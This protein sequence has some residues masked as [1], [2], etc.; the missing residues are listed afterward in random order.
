[1]T[2]ED[3]NQEQGSLVLEMRFSRVRD[4][5]IL[6]P[7]LAAFFLVS[8]FIDLLP[9]GKIVFGMPTRFLQIFLTWAILI[10][11]VYILNARLKSS[12]EARQK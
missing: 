9:F 12:I 1:M 8:P 7:W 10:V 11:L 4:A 2:N 6:L 3:K 5:L